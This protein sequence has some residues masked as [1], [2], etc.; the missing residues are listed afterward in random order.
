MCKQFVSLLQNIGPCIKV[1]NKLRKKVNDIN[2]FSGT[3]ILKKKSCYKLKN[4]ELL[5]AT[6]L[7]NINI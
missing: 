2:G 4:A 6:M 5:F 1:E 3:K 7:S